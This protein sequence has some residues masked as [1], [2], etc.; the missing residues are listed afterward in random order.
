MALLVSTRPNQFINPAYSK[1]T[2]FV[3]RETTAAI[4]T[5][6]GFKFRFTIDIY[7]VSELGLSTFQTH[8]FLVKPNEIGVGALDLSQIIQDYAS[9]DIELYHATNST[10][11]HNGV[12]ADSGQ[13][14]ND[15]RF[16]IHIVD[17]FSNQHSNVIRLLIS[18]EG[19]YIN[20]GVETINISNQ[21]LGNKYFY[22]NGTQQKEDGTD[23][24]PD[25]NYLMNNTSDEF[26]SDFAPSINR[27][28]RR[29]DYHTLSFLNGK[30]YRHLSNTIASSTSSNVSSLRFSFY[31]S[32]NSLISTYQLNNT[33]ANGGTPNPDHNAVANL[34]HA[35]LYAGVGVQNLE[36]SGQTVPATT[37]YYTVIARNSSG[38]QVSDTYRFDI[39]DEDCKGFETI[40]LAYLNRLGAWDYY[41][42]NKKS[43]RSVDTQ[44]GLMKENH[45]QFYNFTEAN[46]HF[47]GGTKVY[48]TQAKEIIEA[49]TDFIDENEASALESLFTSPQVYIQD[50]NKYYPVVVAEKTYTKQTTANDGL[51]QYVISIEKS[52]NRVIQRL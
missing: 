48:K 31:D 40:R 23:D 52:N 26:L 33:A 8:K 44:R 18:V 21:S 50:G 6:P 11:Q 43:V 46:Q 37:S 51:K 45:K 38:T 42:F 36:N 14:F 3:V 4:F 7:F 17:K 49:N 39:Q 35:L 5:Q 25:S 10:A 2:T 22:W 19:F 34:E 29:T 32:S 47:M 24:F 27:K 41:N 16:P 13:T 1:H 28:V 20:N 9:T 12:A 15:R 30:F